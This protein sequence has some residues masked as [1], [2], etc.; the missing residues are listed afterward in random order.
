M[1]GVSGGEGLC[2][3]MFVA[4]LRLR[5]TARSGRIFGDLATKYHFHGGGICRIQHEFYQCLWI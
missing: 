5:Q 3:K 2:V 4:R 1:P